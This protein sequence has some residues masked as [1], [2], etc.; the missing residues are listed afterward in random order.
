MEP[1]RQL[2]LWAVVDFLLGISRRNQI[3]G[4]Q[5]QP[6]QHH[7]GDVDRRVST[8]QNTDKQGDGEAEQVVATKEQQSGDRQQ[9][10]DRRGHGPQQGLRGRDVD[11]LDQAGLA[12]H[13]EVLTNPV[14]YHDGVVERV[15]DDRQYRRQNRQVEGDLE[16]REYTHGHDHVVDQRDNGTDRELP[17]KA[18]SQV[19]QDTAQRH[20]HAEA[21]L[22]AQF[23]TD[24]RAYELDTLDLSRVVAADFLQRFSHLVT[25][26]RVFARH[27]HQQI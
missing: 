16:E 20:Q 17:L 26:L 22:V 12:Q 18:E 10:G 27:A 25:Q 23:F 2:P 15:T 24:L 6:D 5:A 9:G 4:A 21:A 11:V 7:V 19:D 3:L 14:E 1:E 13:T 8:R